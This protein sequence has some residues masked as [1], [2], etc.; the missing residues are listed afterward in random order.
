VKKITNQDLTMTGKT[1]P[2]H[3]NEF[4]DYDRLKKIE[5]KQ[6]E[7]PKLTRVRYAIDASADS[8]VD[9]PFT[10]TYGSTYKANRSENRRDRLLEL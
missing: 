7:L 9:Q 8:I 5:N 2:I 4:P 1:A 3:L 6:T 10:E